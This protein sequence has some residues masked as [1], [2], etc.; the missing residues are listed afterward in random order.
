MPVRASLSAVVASAMLAS[1]LPAVP[2]RPAPGLYANP[3]CVSNCTTTVTTT[4]TTPAPAP[5]KGEAP[6]TPPTPPH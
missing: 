3:R 2:D 5:G 1:C 4:V 6:A